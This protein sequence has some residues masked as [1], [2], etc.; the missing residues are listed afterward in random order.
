MAVYEWV[1]ARSGARRC[2]ITQHY[3]T[4]ATMA[5]NRAGCTG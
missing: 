2:R 4:G 1:S 5:T 3:A